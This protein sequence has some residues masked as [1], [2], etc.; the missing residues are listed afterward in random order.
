MILNARVPFSHQNFIIFLV[1]APRLTS[2]KF[3]VEFRSRIDPKN[4]AC[5]PRSEFQTG[6]RSD[7]HAI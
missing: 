6:T 1:V 2:L 7:S 3:R 5:Q 4:L